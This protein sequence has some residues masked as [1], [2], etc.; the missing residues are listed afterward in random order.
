MIIL[1]H[2]SG[3]DDSKPEQWMGW[4]GKTCRL[5]GETVLVVPGVGTG[6]STELLDRVKAFFDTLPKGDPPHSRGIAA[7]TN[8]DRLKA[9]KAADKEI[10]T[11]LKKYNFKN[12]KELVKELFKKASAKRIKDVAGAGASVKFRVAVASLCALAYYRKTPAREPIRIVGHSR[13]GTAAL[14]THNLLTHYG[15][16]CQ[17]TLL[18]DPVHGGKK[19]FGHKDYYQKAWSGHVVWMT[20]PRS[21]VMASVPIKASSSGDATVIELPKTNSVKHGH[22]GK[23][24][25]FKEKAEG[26]AVLKPKLERLTADIGIGAKR[27]KGPEAIT[28]ET[29]E[30]MREHLIMLFDKTLNPRSSDKKRLATAV[31]NTVAGSAH[32]R[33][34][35][36]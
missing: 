35:S 12:E 29:K 36:L 23:F 20:A 28:P 21:S 22:M 14:V 7:G 3:D 18:L 25:A 13:G 17:H 26:R 5:Y 10:G 11:V 27:K 19:M 4:F 9:L 32:D 2:G 6:E 16:P 24:C 1:M 8:K 33:E 30:V 34:V 15:V 31:I